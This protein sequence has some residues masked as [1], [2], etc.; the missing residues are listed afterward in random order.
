[1]TSEPIDL[2]ELRRAHAAQIDV[3]LAENA[4]LRRALE[5]K[6][7]PA[8]FTPPERRSHPLRT[9]VKRVM[10]NRLRS[11]IARMMKQADR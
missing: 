11:R 3:L 2:E 7:D 9:L 6:I 10:P 8:L 4:R 1:M 5:G